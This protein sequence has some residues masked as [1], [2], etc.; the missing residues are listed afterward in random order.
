M[1]PIQDE[2]DVLVR[3]EAK[4]EQVT[5][6]IARLKKRNE[7]LQLELDEL[8]QLRDEVLREAETARDAAIAEA[9]AAR[10]EVARVHA[11]AETLRTRQKEA[12]SRIKNLLS[13]VEQMDLLTEG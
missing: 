6:V 4:L 2:D 11:E 9:E 8:N 7:E 3:L 1:Q 10:A 13:Q 12:A 5:A